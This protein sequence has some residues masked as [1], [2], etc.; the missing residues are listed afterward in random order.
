[1]TTQKE[2]LREVM[3]QFHS[4]S[5]APG[6]ANAAFDCAGYTCCFFVLASRPSWA[7]GIPVAFVQM[8]F[9]ARL[10]ILGHD[11]CH[12][13]LFRPR[14]LNRLLGRIF[15]LP[16]MT[17]Y[18]LWELGHNSVHH[19]FSN[20]KGRDYVWTPFSPEDWVR[21]PRRRRFLERLYR[22]PLGLGVYYFAEL[23]WK[24]MFFPRRGSLTSYRASYFWDNLLNIAFLALQ[25]AA[26]RLI[27]PHDASQVGTLWFAVVAPFVL[28]NYLMGFAIY[29]HH[30]HP[31]VRW[32]DSRTE[33]SF[34]EAQVRS[35]THTTFPGG[36][37]WLLHNIFEHTA[38]HV[39]TAIPF[40]ELRAAQ[41]RIEELCGPDIVQV[42]IFSA[43]AF[44]AQM[45]TCQLYEYRK[46]RWVRFQEAELGRPIGR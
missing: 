25:I 35:T 14:F 5:N 36:V 33:W 17:P 31:D 12:G 16:S 22:C 28:W 7:V 37:G 38:H 6:L 19:G 8:M 21:L 42:E 18:T 27:A 1:M 20:L 3:A 29:C 44:L 39:D 15:F 4:R 32:F 41:R 30:T 43:R 24:R 13:A 46:H 9:I 34:Y 26:A 10:F 11:A 45:R 23:W 40:Y 2:R